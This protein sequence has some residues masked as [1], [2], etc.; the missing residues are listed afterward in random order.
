LEQKTI[1]S[2]ADDVIAYDLKAHTLLCAELLN[3]EGVDRLPEET[4]SDLASRLWASWNESVSTAADQS[5]FPEALMTRLN[6]IKALTLLKE[7]TKETDDSTSA[8][9]LAARKEIANGFKELIDLLSDKFAPAKFVNSS[10]FFSILVELKTQFIVAEMYAGIQEESGFRNYRKGEGKN[11]IKSVFE[12]ST[13]PNLPPAVSDKV[14]AVFKER[15]AQIYGLLNQGKMTFDAFSMS[16]LESKIR[17]FLIRIVKDLNSLSLPEVMADSEEI[18]VVRSRPGDVSESFSQIGKEQM[19]QLLN[20]VEM[21][22][23]RY[24]S[25]PMVNEF[26]SPYM[27]LGAAEP[28]ASPVKRVRVDE[29]Y[30]TRTPVNDSYVPGSSYNIVLDPTKPLSRFQAGSTVPRRRPP[31]VKV[32]W[33]EEETA[34]LEQGMNIFGNDWKAIK[35]HFKDVLTRRSN[36]NL[37]D[38][39]RNIKRKLIKMGAPLGIWANACN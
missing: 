21:V 28:W 25:I 27:N 13:V 24:D 38:R 30:V 11:L 20:A 29:G 6:M 19:A 17:S 5:S 9:A 14:D 31:G 37:K 15:E 22:T 3:G 7:V 32:P 18:S 23:H 2:S 8:E 26:D 1:P 16:D 36:V 35:D 10:M 4:N 39:A 12:I 33:T 34:A